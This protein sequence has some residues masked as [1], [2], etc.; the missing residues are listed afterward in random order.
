[1]DTNSGSAHGLDLFI[2]STMSKLP[3]YE[4]IALIPVYLCV[5]VQL[6]ILLFNNLVIPTL[7]YSTQVIFG[8]SQVCSLTML[9]SSQ[10]TT[11]L[12]LDLLLVIL[13]YYMK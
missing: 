6:S 13:L 9:D 12:C 2:I 10:L 1:M 3:W 5:N 7:Q 8:K 4:V 11:L